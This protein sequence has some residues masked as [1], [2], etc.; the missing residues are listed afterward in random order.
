M[1]G[2]N[3][4]ESTIARKETKERCMRSCTDGRADNAMRAVVRILQG[5]YP[6]YMVISWTSP[7]HLPENLHQIRAKSGVKFS[8]VINLN[9]QVQGPKEWRNIVEVSFNG[10]YAIGMLRF[11]LYSVMEI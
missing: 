11:G 7:G 4:K 2:N 3:P 1:A 8:S 5:L 10:F 6:V 9:N